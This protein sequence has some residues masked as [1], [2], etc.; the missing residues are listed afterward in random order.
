MNESIAYLG[1]LA[2]E[3]IE[4]DSAALM[5]SALDHEG[6]DVEPYLVLLR[7]IGA[8]PL[9]RGSTNRQT[10]P[11]RGIGRRPVGEGANK[12]PKNCRARTG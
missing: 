12:R 7:R 8:A 2:D 9:H 3:D 1:L 5:L 11:Q 4:L 10:N 6:I